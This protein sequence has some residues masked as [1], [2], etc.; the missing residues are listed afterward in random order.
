MY[1]Q[2]GAIALDALG[3]LPAVS[4]AGKEWLSMVQASGSAAFWAKTVLAVTLARLL[5][6]PQGY[7]PSNLSGSR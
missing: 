3:N 4:L 2:G 7:I 1:P 5:R 6:F